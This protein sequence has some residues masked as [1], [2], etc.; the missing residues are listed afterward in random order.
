MPGSAAPP[1][2]LRCDS[3]LR[4]RKIRKGEPRARRSPTTP[5]LPVLQPLL[6]VLQAG[7]QVPDAHLLLLQGGQVLLR[8]WWFDAMVVTAQVVFGRAPA[9]TRLSPSCWHGAV[10]PMD[11]SHTH[12]HCPEQS[13]GERT[14]SMETPNQGQ[15]HQRC[16][17]GWAMMEQVGASHASQATTAAP[18]PLCVA[19]ST[20]EVDECLWASAQGSSAIMRWRGRG[21]ERLLLHGYTH[22]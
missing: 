20:A 14:V 18:D 5:H 22:G 15:S 19:T 21:G 2:A 10:L 3:E 11:T 8:C 16:A 1:A 12:T 17:V 4:F 9:G 6:R 13:L 7:L